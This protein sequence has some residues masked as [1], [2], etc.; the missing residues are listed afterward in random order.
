MSQDTTTA[1]TAT[2]KQKD[3]FDASA[4]ALG[5]LYQCWFALLLALQR[6]EDSSESVTLEKLDG[7]HLRELKSWKVPPRMHELEM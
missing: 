4:S 5:Y 2:K 1:Q 7:S 6:D 3:I